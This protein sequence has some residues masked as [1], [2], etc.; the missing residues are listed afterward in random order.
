ME[1]SLIVA[2]NEK[3]TAFF[4]G[5][6]NAA[7]KKHIS[8]LNGG[9]ARRI[10][11]EKD[12][13]FAIINTP[14]N[15]EFGSELAIY[16]SEELNINTILV[17]KKDI[18]EE[19]REK[20]E[21]FGITVVSRPLNKETLYQAYILQKSIRRKILG[22]KNENDRLKNKIEE[23]KAVDRA[24]CLLIE[25]EKMSENEAHKYIEQNAM[26]QRRKKMEIAREI[27]REYDW[28]FIL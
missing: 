10:A 15:D 11:N 26:K 23:I 9:E 3:T 13:D 18:S 12:I 2:A 7:K 19:I 6:F 5:F 21:E 24:K 8:S 1:L 17:V 20:T 16:F 22:I 27:I 4:E 28:V 25:H 14:L